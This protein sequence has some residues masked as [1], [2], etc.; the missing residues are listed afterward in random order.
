MPFQ[1]QRL[2]I[3]DVILVQCDTRPDPRGFFRETYKASEFAANGIPANFVQDNH[4]HSARGVL[5]GLHYQKSPQAQGKLV[6][7]ITGEIFDVAVDIR[8]GSPTYGRWVTKTLTASDGC[9]LYVPPG[10]AHGFCVLSEWA[11]FLYKVTAEYAPDCE[12]GIIW[13]DP[14][15]GVQWPIAKPSLSER[16]SHLPRLRDADNNFVFVPR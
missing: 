6:T 9:M 2:Q 12:R 10:F 14:D 1:F 15:I 16:D 8:R 4:S 13:N 7:V 3:S 11:D 5:R